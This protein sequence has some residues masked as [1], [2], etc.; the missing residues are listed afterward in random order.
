MDRG[1]ELEHCSWK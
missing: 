1:M